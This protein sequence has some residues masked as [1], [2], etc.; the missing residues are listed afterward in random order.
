MSA[1][2]RLGMTTYGAHVGVVILAG[3]GALSAAQIT[4]L[5]GSCRQQQLCISGKTA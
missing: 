4:R 3:I 1:M 2:H 5:W